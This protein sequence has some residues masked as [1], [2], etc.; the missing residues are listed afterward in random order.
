M[1]LFVWWIQSPTQSPPFIPSHA[2]DRPCVISPNFSGS[3]PLPRQVSPN[4]KVKPL[5]VSRRATTVPT[6]FPLSTALSALLTSQG[7]R[8]QLCH[9]LPTSHCAL[10]MLP[11]D[12]LHSCYTGDTKTLFERGERQQQKK[13]K[14]IFWWCIL[15]S[16]L[17]CC[18][19]VAAQEYRDFN[20]HLRVAQS[21]QSCQWQSFPILVVYE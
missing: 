20:I 8:A 14:I 7:N 17:K 10:W 6:G 9:P 21:S 11:P 2:F 18:H 19:L 3:S 5:P 1:S 16:L 12:V 15:Q 13:T 4:S